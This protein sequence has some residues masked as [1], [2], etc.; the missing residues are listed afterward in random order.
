[1]LLSIRSCS[2]MHFNCF[3]I[4]VLNIIISYD[5]IISRNSNTTRTALVITKNIVSSLVVMY[6]FVNSKTSEEIIRLNHVDILEEATREQGYFGPVSQPIQGL[7]AIY[8]NLP[9]MDEFKR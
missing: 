5:R 1:M 8:Q 6:D 2:F 7:N 9:G 3:S 4:N